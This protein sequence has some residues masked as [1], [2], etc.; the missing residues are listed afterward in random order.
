LTAAGREPVA[1]GV[2][3]VAVEVVAVATEGSRAPPRAQDSAHRPTRDPQL[4][5][6]GPLVGPPETHQI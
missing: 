3:V 1:V 6:A 5:N 4:G 2:G